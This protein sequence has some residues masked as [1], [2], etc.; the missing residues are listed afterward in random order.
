VEGPPLKVIA[1]ELSFLAGATIIS[2]SGT[3]KIEKTVL[4]GK[5]I[6]KIYSRGKNLLSQFPE[7]TIRVH[8]V[9]FGSYSVNNPKTNTTPSLSL[10]TQKAIIE[11]YRCSIKMLRNE[12]VDAL[13]DEEVDIMSDNWNAKKVFELTLRQPKELICDLLLDQ[14]IFAG[15]GNIIKNEALFSAGVH[16]LSITGKIPKEKIEEIINDARKFSK[17]FYTTRKNGQELKTHLKVYQKP[18]CPNSQ[19]EVVR[20]VTGKRKRLSHFCPDRQFHYQ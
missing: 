1:E 4:E 9:M 11:F 10:K 8:F 16:P 2:A 19:Q 3:A 14:A 5:S 7:S 13:F 12:E 17:L 20:M 18:R 15:V 6:E